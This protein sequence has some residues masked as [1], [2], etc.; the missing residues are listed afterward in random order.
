MKVNSSSNVIRLF[1]GDSSRKERRQ[2][3]QQEQKKEDSKQEKQHPTDPEAFEAKVNSAIY[4]FGLDLQAQNQGLKVE[5]EGHGLGLKVVLKDGMG[6]VVR[7]LSGEEFLELRQAT[8][9]EARSRGRLL[10]RKF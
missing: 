7:Q 9:P 3:Q 10:D 1:Q 6:A 8:S 5:K 2:G 4:S